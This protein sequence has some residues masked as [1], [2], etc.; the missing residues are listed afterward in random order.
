[1]EHNIRWKDESISDVK[2]GYV[3]SFHQEWQG[4]MKKIWHYVSLTEIGSTTTVHGRR[5]HS[6]EADR[7]AVVLMGIP[8]TYRLNQTVAVS[9]GMM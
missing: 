9:N 6:H 4:S 7:E 3:K 1:M 2:E 8:K 5:V